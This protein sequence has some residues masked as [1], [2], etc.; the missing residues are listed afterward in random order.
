M[1]DDAMSELRSLCRSAIDGDVPPYEAAHAMWA[2]GMANVPTGD[3][4]EGVGDEVAW[5]HWLIWGALTDWIELRPEETAEVDL[6]IL[7]IAR[8]WLDVEADPVARSTYLDH[9]VH[10]TLGYQR[11]DASP[12]R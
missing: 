3:P 1:D 12:P 7:E 9:V 10:D 2:L 5:A 6:L 8:G 11:P 4:V